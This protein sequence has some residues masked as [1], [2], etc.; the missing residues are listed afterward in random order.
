MSIRRAPARPRPGRCSRAAAAQARPLRCS[1]SR[2][3]SHALLSARGKRVDD[4]TAD[5]HR[6]RAERK[7]AQDVD[8]A[9]NAAVEE[10]L[11][12]SVDG[13]DDLRQRVD[14]RRHAVEL[15][16]AVI[17]HDD[18]RRAVLDGEPRI[19]AR[20]HALEHDR[21]PVPREP[22]EVAPADARVDVVED[23]A[24]DLELVG[25]VEADSGRRP[26]GG[27]GSARRRSARAPSSRAHTPRRSVPA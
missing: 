25:D 1:S 8:A 19:F 16:P 13:L 2:T 11:G 14:R 24:G 4:R 17:G 23:V 27:R 12:T 9:A 20:Q 7:R 15:T 5:E 22:L 26:R 3:C 21:Q 10:D 18:G 6:P